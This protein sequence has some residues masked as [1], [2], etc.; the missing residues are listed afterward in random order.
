MSTT[1]DLLVKAE[2]KARELRR[3]FIVLYTLKSSPAYYFAGM[4]NA[5]ILDLNPYPVIVQIQVK[6]NAP[7]W[8]KKALNGR[9]FEVSSNS[10]GDYAR[11]ECQLKANNY[12]HHVIF[13]HTS[14]VSYG[15]L[16]FPF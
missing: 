2:L 14:G 15:Q 10:E 9:V 6:D 4:E 11:I 5:I 13:R 8:M 16:E 3:R 1:H 7:Q 12:A